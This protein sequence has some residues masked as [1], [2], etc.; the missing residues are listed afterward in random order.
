MVATTRQPLPIRS[1]QIVAQPLA[2]ILTSKRGEVLLVHKMGIARLAAPVSSVSKGIYDAIFVGNLTP[3]HVA[4]LDEL[5][6]VTNNRVLGW[7]SRVA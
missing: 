1:R 6:P 5:F 7:R 3:S 4:A 2:H